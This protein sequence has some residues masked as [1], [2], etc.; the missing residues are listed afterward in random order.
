MPTIPPAVLASKIYGCWLGKAVGGTLGTPH[1]GKPGPLALSYYD[2]VPRTSLPNDDLDL[3]VVWLHHLR[4]TR[5]TTVTPELLAEAWQRHVLFPF[6][7]YAIARRN[8][9][10]GLSGAAQG[11]TDNYFG[12]CMG[13][14]IRSEIWA[15]IAPGDPERAAGLAWADAVVDHCG[16]G[17][18]AE[19]F[20]AVIESAAFHETDRDR[21]IQ[22]GLSYLPAHSRLKR[23][24][25]DTLA[26]WHER[27]DWRYVRERV[28][29]RHHPGNF[30]DVVCNLCFELIG[31]FDGNG[32][33]GR[34]I[35]TAVNCGL[36]TDCTGATLGALLGIIDPERIPERWRMPIGEDIVL[37]EAIVDLAK[38]K[39]LNELTAW[40][41]EV[42]R[43]LAEFRPVRGPVLPH[44]PASPATAVRPI[45][46]VE[47][48]SNDAAILDSAAVPGASGWRSAPLSGFWSVWRAQDFAERV[49]I[50]RLHFE[51]EHNG[52]VKLMLFYRARGAAWIDGRRVL[53]VSA[54]AIDADPFIAPSFHRAGPTAAVVAGLAAGAHELVLALE[55]PATGRSVDLVFGLADPVSNL[56]LPHAF[57]PVAAPCSH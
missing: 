22:I 54:A 49:R 43:Q 40:T 51:L 7:E 4:R 20:H 30:T 5:A 10:W 41:I 35:C 57:V 39:D 3:Q 15:C 27:P 42:G 8:R 29:E 25:Q 9:A 31:W 11:A 37:S 23:A 34:S 14:A 18:L 48:C 50:L 19:V 12:E 45:P 38:P 13:A 46:A 6:D 1:E 28:I 16:E 32:D 55:A 33:F 36:D 47:A 26:W 52:D 53:T 21:L 2:P 44:L 24:L 56:W 17:V